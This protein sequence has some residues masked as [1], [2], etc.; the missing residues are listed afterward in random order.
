MIDGKFVTVILFVPYCD[1]DFYLNNNIPI[2]CQSVLSKLH[3]CEKQ[4]NYNTKR[5]AKFENSHINNH[6]KV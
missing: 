2:S 5:A 3:F 4:L 6:Y 1:Y